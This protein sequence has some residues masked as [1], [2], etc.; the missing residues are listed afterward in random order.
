MWDISKL[1]LFSGVDALSVSCEGE[2]FLLVG[3]RNLRISS[4]VLYQELLSKYHRTTVMVPRLVLSE[5]LRE[6]VTYAD[7]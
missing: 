3:K 7:E 1:I 4:S 6:V 5:F 2:M